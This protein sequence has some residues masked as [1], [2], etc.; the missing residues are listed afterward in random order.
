MKRNDR[1]GSTLVTIGLALMVTT[2]IALLFTACS[3]DGDDGSVLGPCYHEYRDAVVHISTLTD[4]DSGAFL[5]TMYISGVT[6][7]GTDYPLDWIL[8]A[9]LSEGLQAVGDSVLCVI[10][11]SFGSREGRWSMTVSAP[12]YPRQVLEFEAAYALFHGGCPSWND[13]GTLV[14]LRLASEVF[15]GSPD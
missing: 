1:C 3:D 6:V 14:D 9:R 12:G 4:L 10:P 8:E 5:D 11:C 13:E 2:L 7:R 15:V